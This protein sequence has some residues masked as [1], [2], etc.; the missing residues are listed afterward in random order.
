M[1]VAD[2][3]A[4]QNA[5][6]S[7]CGQDIAVPRGGDASPQ[8]SPGRW[9]TCRTV[10]I[11]FMLITFVG[12]TIGL[13][14]PAV[15]APREGLRRGQCRNNLNQIGLAMFNYQQQYGC[16]P[17]A[18]IPDKN[19]KPKHSWRV[20]ILPFLDE[21]GLYKQ[22]RFDEPWN[23]P[24]NKELA[25]R[26]PA[27]Y[28][29]PSEAPP[30]TSY[31]SYAMIVGPHAIS[32]GPTPRKRDDVKDGI[33]NTI[34]V[35]ECAGADI[36]WLEPR[37]VNAASIRSLW[38]LGDE[39]MKPPSGISSYHSGMANVLFCDGTVRAIRSSVD[40]KLLRA[41]LTIDGGEPVNVDD[42][43]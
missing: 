7:H 19:G 5:S 21:V 27:V 10:T 13:L 39:G 6:C 43:R 3:Y 33:S 42:L 22:Y 40:E 18:F 20:L 31:T 14:L 41:M 29:C 28:R 34:M 32:D 16:F 35:A 36:N 37:D 24:H 8:R 9:F 4:G 1:D 30:G 38:T 2:Q 11:V 23:G 15:N 12:M 26:M 17:P 25:A